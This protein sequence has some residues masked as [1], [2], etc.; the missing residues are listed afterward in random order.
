MS[1]AAECVG[2]DEPHTAPEN[3]EKKLDDDEY[4]Y[5]D[6]YSQDAQKLIKEDTFVAS[7]FDSNKIQQEQNSVQQQ[8]QNPVQQQKQNPAQQRKA[9][10]AANS[11]TF[12]VALGFTLAAC[13]ILTNYLI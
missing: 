13:G 6:D 1:T 5:D 12:S 3:P 9:T 8:N 7:G 4:E 2:D 11:I 10:S